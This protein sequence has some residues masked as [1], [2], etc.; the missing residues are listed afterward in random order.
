MYKLL[1]YKALIESQLIDLRNP[2]LEL[3]GHNQILEEISKAN[4]CKPNYFV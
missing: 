2:F 1:N 4:W 3:S